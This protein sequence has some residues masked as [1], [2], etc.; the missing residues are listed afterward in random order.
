MTIVGIAGNVRHFGLDGEPPREIYRPYSQAAWPVMTITV[1][2]ATDPLLAASSVRAALRRIDP[3]QPVTQVRTMDQ[4]VFTSSGSRRF[5][6]LLFATFALV[7]LLLAIVGVYGVVSYLVSQRTKEIGIR[8][9]LGAHRGSVTRLVVGRSLI[10]IA[11]GIAI[12]LGGALASSR[13]LETML[14]QVEPNDPIVLAGISG[15]LLA[16]A[17]AASWVPARRAAGVDPLL[18]LRQE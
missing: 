10:P 3:E 7:A 12:G 8:V 2:T 4:V 15:L 13:L 17:I 11:A 5:P 1:K 18:V 6:M 9:A 14:F 16:A